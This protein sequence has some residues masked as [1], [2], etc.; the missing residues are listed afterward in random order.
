MA[1]SRR[2]R[3]HRGRAALIAAAA[4]CAT[5]LAGLPAVARAQIV[6]GPGGRP[7]GVLARD[8]AAA[9]STPAAAQA[10]PAAARPAPAVARTTPAAPRATSAPN[11]ASAGGAA[12][13]GGFESLVDQFFTDLAASS[14]AGATDNV[15]AVA[16]QYGDAFDEPL[17]RNV[18][19][20]LSRRYS[21]AFAAPGDAF[22]DSE[23]FPADRDNSIGGPGHNNPQG[24]APDPGTRWATHRTPGA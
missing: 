18:P 16:A 23:P 19:D 14:A 7:V 1:T 4:T 11:D 17:A 22:D 3:G 24:C 8:P 6:S 15:Y 9:A 21:V 2:R 5:A 10:T 20:D 13:P 12:F